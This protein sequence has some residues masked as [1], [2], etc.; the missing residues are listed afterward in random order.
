MKVAWH[1][2][3]STDTLVIEGHVDL[4]AAAAAMQRES[5]GYEF[6]AP[7]HAWMR[8]MRV[9]EAVP[10]LRGGSRRNAPEQAL[11]AATAACDFDDTTY[12]VGR[13]AKKPRREP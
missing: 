4:G 3:E 2:N 9:L 6:P 12:N 11:P 5:S 7:C 8:Y 13:F 1:V 10:P